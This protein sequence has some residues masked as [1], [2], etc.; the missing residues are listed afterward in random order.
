MS[1]GALT[2]PRGLSRDRTR[3]RKP[4]GRNRQVGLPGKNG[5][6]Y[7][8]VFTYDYRAYG[9]NAAAEY[10]PRETVTRRGA[11]DKGLMSEILKA[12]KKGGRH[13]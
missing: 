11:I 4:L 7:T 13:A 12:G 10:R 8:A 1:C 9:T 6:E 5:K 3:N 2:V